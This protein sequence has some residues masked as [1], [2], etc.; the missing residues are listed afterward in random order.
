M[1]KPFKMDVEADD[2]PKWLVLAGR[3]LRSQDTPTP[4]KKVSFDKALP[5]TGK[6]FRWTAALLVLVQIDAS[7]MSGYRGDNDRYPGSDSRRRK[8]TNESA[9]Y[10]FNLSHVP[11]VSPSVPTCSGFY[12]DIGTS[13]GV[14]VRKLFQPARYPG[15]KIAAKFDQLFGARVA[16]FA[17]LALSPIHC[18]GNAY[19]AWK[20]R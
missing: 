18:T 16:T 3:I 2:E 10:L 11:A 7:R 4:K 20:P 9:M 5:V 6:M 19:D 14:Q 12:I 8:A 13:I 17:R 1:V 15:A